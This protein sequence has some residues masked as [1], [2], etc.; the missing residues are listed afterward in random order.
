MRTAPQTKLG[1]RRKV[2]SPADL[3]LAQSA[4][5]PVTG[6]TNLSERKL[7]L[8]RER[9]PWT[10]AQGVDVARMK[11]TFVRKKKK[12]K[13]KRKSYLSD[14]QSLCFRFKDPAVRI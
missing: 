11:I 14:W 9:V 1:G 3:P 5:L 4:H 13:K 8:G 12:K 6:G 7:R 2:A 10:P